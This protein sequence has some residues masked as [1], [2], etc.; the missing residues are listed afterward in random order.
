MT[1]THEILA[2]Y[3]ESPPSKVDSTLAV[4]I[5]AV[6]NLC[7]EAF[8]DRGDE[9]ETLDLDVRRGKH[10]KTFYLQNSQEPVP[11]KVTFDLCDRCYFMTT[12]KINSRGLYEKL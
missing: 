8:F 10:R 1:L 4:S 9:T 12:H 5:D 7:L 11:V 2:C 6:C 3:L